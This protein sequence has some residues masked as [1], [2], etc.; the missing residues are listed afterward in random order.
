V[1][2][3]VF[4]A[5]VSG[6]APASI[7]YGDDTVMA[8]M[9]ISPVNAGH[10][11]VIPRRHMAAL[12]DLDE[13]TGARLF[14]IATRLS[15]ALRRSGVRCE[16]VNL[17]LADGEAAFQEVFHVH[18]HVVPR[19]A[20]DAFRIVDEGTSH[21]SRGDLDAISAQIREAD[22]LPR[23]VPGLDLPNR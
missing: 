23:D 2:N 20:G 6:D 7:V 10:L 18:L 1:D 5:I 3:C 16:G 11:L 14:N 9:D 4:C 15:R 21:P 13:E 8:F 12:A 17:F 19:F 22:Q